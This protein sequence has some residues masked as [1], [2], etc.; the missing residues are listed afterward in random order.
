MC[1]FRCVSLSIQILGS[2]TNFHFNKNGDA[3]SCRITNSTSEHIKLQAQKT[4]TSDITILIRL[5][6]CKDRVRDQI[7]G[8][9]INNAS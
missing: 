7:K 1:E 8:K 4:S 5:V 2:Y 3:Q 6:R 9:R